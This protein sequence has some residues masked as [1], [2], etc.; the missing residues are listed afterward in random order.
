MRDYDQ[1]A[2]AFQAANVRVVALTSASPETIATSKREHGLEM[3]ILSVE[4]AL[5][6]RW[7]LA[8]P[9]KPDLPHP[10]TIRV[11]TD[12]VVQSIDVHTNYKER[13]DVQAMADALAP[14]GPP[15]WDNAARLE[16][17]VVSEGVLLRVVLQPGF[18]VYGAKEQIGNPLAVRVTDRPDVQ[19]QV[20]DGEAKE[21]PG[22]GTAWVL[23][24]SV[25]LVVPVATPASGEVDVQ[26]CT[27]ATCSRPTTWTWS[28]TGP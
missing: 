11:G 9:D 12:G 23:S 4:P 26:I 13:S 21:L 16:T 14:P 20:P 25:E 24:G 22:L 19:V 17:E 3:E 8:N 7:G 1:H 6:A 15:D 2:D 10:A 18:H 5:W 27:A 28:E